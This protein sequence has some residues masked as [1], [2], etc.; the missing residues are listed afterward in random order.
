MQH[1]WTDVDSFGPCWGNEEQTA[2]VHAS[3]MNGTVVS[4]NSGIPTS[5]GNPV[6]SVQAGGTRNTLYPNWLGALKC[7]PSWDD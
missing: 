5:E 3:L 1:P 7:L 2:S 6:S 4:H